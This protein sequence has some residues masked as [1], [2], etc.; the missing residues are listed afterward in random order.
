MNAYELL[1]VD[2]LAD[3]DKIKQAYR[4][5]AK[6]LHP[7]VN[8]GDEEAADR[9]KHITAAYN[10]LA[11]AK[12]RAEYDRNAGRKGGAPGYG[13]PWE[14]GGVWYDFEI[15]ETTGERINDLYGDVAGTRLGRVK[16]AAATSMKVKGQ[17]V[18]AKLKITETE[19][20]EGICK[21]VTTMTGLSV[22]VDVPAGHI[23]G[24]TIKIP[25]F[26]IEGFGGAEPGDLNVI[27]EI[28][29]DPSIEATKP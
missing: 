12:K 21:L 24:K 2:R 29:P 3:L 23:N 22:A 5:L 8:S 6:E 19:A 18:A 14:K 28:V 20:R 10:L 1:G 4:R 16:G 15:D 9:F 7:D 11:D 26:G 13:A 27:V 25:G 17:D